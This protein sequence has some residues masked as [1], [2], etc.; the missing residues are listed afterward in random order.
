MSIG[1]AAGAAIEARGK[2][3]RGLLLNLSWAV[4]LLAVVWLAADSWGARAL[5]FGSAVAYCVMS[6]WGFLYIAAD[7]PSG[8]LPRL[9]WTLAF[10]LCLTAACLLLSPRVRM[11]SAAPA[12]LL[13]AY[14]TLTVF[15]DRGLMLAV[16][17]RAKARLKY[18]EAAVHGK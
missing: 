10:T 14:L 7:L 2:M 9:F 4:V 18:R 13:T 15:V 11:V 12:A 16:A 8:M 3:W 1:S 6:V 5:A 17:G